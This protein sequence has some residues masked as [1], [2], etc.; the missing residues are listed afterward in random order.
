MLIPFL[1]YTTITVYHH[2]ISKFYLYLLLSSSL[3]IPR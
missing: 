3:F 1:F 2:F